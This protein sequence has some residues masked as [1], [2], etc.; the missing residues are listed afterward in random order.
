M[1]T[2]ALFLGLAIVLVAILAVWGYRKLTAP[3]DFQN[4]L[5]MNHWCTGCSLCATPRPNMKCERCEPHNQD[6]Y[7]VV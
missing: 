7:K 4:G 6:A 2:F 3:D 5:V 1:L